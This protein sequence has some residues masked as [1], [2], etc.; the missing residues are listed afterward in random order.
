MFS[1]GHL[2]YLWTSLSGDWGQ[3]PLRQPRAPGVIL[4]TR[5]QGLSQPS[6]SRTSQIDPAQ[7]LYIWPSIADCDGRDNAPVIVCPALSPI[8]MQPAIPQINLSPSQG[9]EFSGPQSMPISE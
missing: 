1:D 7:A 8:H 5:L 6:P 3:E 2:E 4:L 9:A